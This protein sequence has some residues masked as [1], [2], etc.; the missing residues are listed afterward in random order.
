[1][2]LAD[3]YG[4]EPARFL[5]RPVP[6]SLRTIK[7]RIRGIETVDEIEQWTA[8]EAA[9]GPRQDVIAALNQRKAELA[10]GAKAE[11]EE[12]PA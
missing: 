2:T 5:A 8:C 10:N 4:E 11:S 9:I 7:A 12:V 6:S 3:E 1:M